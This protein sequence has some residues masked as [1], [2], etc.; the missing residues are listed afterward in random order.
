MRQVLVLAEQSESATTARC[1][2]VSG[3]IER[4]NKV[5]GQSLETTDVGV[6]A[7]LQAICSLYNSGLIVFRKSSETSGNILY[8]PSK[9]S[10]YSVWTQEPL[11]GL[12]SKILEKQ[13]KTFRTTEGAIF[14]FPLFDGDGFI[15]A[16]ITDWSPFPAAAAIA[17]HKEHRIVRGISRKNG[18]YFTGRYVRHPLTG[19]LL[20]VWVADWVKPEFGT[21]A[22]IVN[23]AHDN[24]DFEF[25]KTIGLPIRFALAPEVVTSNPETWPYPPILKQ[26]I[27]IKTGQFD[28]LSISEAIESYFK[29]LHDNGFAEKSTDL[30]TG[31]WEIAS[32]QA[33]E[34]VDGNTLFY[35]DEGR[36]EVASSLD[37]SHRNSNYEVLSITPSHLLS[38]LL[39]VDDK[40]DLD[41]IVPSSEVNTSLLLAR[42]LW[43]DL[44]NLPFL[45]RRI[46]TV[47]KAVTTKDSQ[48]VEYQDLQ[49]A[50][51]LKSSLNEVA[52]IKQQVLDQAVS[53]RRRHQEILEN[54][55]VPAEIS[56]DLQSSMWK[57]VYKAKE[58]LVK[59]DLQGTF[60]NIYS[61]QKE[62]SKSPSSNQMN[63]SS[64]A[65]YYVF[66]YIFSGYT[67][68][69]ELNL[70]EIWKS[71]SPESK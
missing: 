3:C 58:C 33:S 34:D 37:E 29:N 6:N 71:I 51:I 28:G 43:V 46:V 47:Q 56:S 36:L 65:A 32:Y 60:N 24:T 15:E 1:E 17:V 12:T 23:P 26:G 11:A 57:L 66:T 69:S 54:A 14:Q 50:S 25:A 64:L 21:G 52:T 19:D 55:S 42:L 10:R 5:E 45:P 61:L 4:L 40:A 38:T 22:V 49:I 68:P 9:S 20:P 16:F 30:S 44:K 39:R 62:I 8:T 13:R 31:I 67:P 53:F 7:S 59:L 18:S 41:L 27:T 70:E 2:A 63:K 48:A 35:I